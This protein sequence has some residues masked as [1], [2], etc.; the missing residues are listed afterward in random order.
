MT[1]KFYFLIGVLISMG[2]MSMVTAVMA[3]PPAKELTALQI[4]SELLGEINLLKGMLGLIIFLYGGNTFWLRRALKK[5]DDKWTENFSQHRS[6]DT[7][8]G[9][10]KALMRFGGCFKNIPDKGD[11]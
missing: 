4:A 9:E 6:Y 5:N 11:N 1:K 2:I 10:H 8:L 7:L 3:Q